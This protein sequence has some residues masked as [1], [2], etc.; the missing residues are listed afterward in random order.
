MKRL[1]ISLYCVFLIF[2]SNAIAVAATRLL[3]EP[4]IQADKIVFVKAGDLWTVSDKGGEAKRLTVHQ[5]IEA[6]PKFSPDGKW[7][8]FSGEYDGN[9]DVFIIPSNGGEP[10]RLTYHP[11]PDTVLGWIPDGTRILFKSSRSSYSGFNRLFT[12]STEGGFPEELPIPMVEYA[13]YSP[14]GSRLAYNP[15]RHFQKWRRYRGGSTPAV[16][17]LN[18]SDFSYEEIP[19]EN[20]SDISP[21]WMGNTV[22]FLSDRDRTLDIYAYDVSGKVLEHLVKNGDFDIENLS[23]DGKRLVYESNGDLYV[24]DPAVGNPQKLRITVPGDQLFVRKHHKNVSKEIMNYDLSP[25]GARAVFEAH[26]EVLTVPAKKGNIR[27]LTRSPGVMDRDPAWSPNGKYIS[28]FSDK[29]GEYALYIIDQKGME[30]AKKIEFKKPSF[31]Y[32]PTWSPDSKK[33]VFTDKHMNIWYVDIEKKNPVKVDTDLFSHPFRTLDPVWS[34]DSNWIAYVR[35]LDNY[36]RTVFVYSLDENKSYQ[37]TDGMSDALYPVFDPEGKYLY[38]TA[39][40][41]AGQS[42]GWLDLTAFDRNINMHIYLVVL[43]KDLPSPLA[44]ESDEEKPEEEQKKDPPKK[45]EKESEKKDPEK[46]KD[47][48]RIDLENIDQRII[49]LPVPP[50]VYSHLRAIKGKF[51]FLESSTTAFFGPPQGTIMLFDFESRKSTTYLTNVTTFNVSADGKKL[52][53][54]SGDNWGIIDTSNKPKPGDGK[55]NL[56]TMDIQINPRAEWK[57][58]LIE[59]WRINRD[60]FYDPGMH[61]VDWEAIR[62]QYTAFL[63]YVAHRSDL[64]FLITEMISEL[65]VGHAYAG[66]GN[67]PDVERVLGGL[68]GADY[69]IENGRYRIKKIYSGLNW[70]PNLRAPLTEPGVDISEGDFI[71]KVNGKP[72]HAPTNIFSL[73][74]KTTEK[75]VT[76][77]VNSSP[78]EKGSRTATVVPIWNEYSLRNRAWVEGN[79]RRVEELSGGRIGYVYLPDTGGGGYTYFNRYFFSQLDKDGLVIDERFNGGGFVADYIIDYLDRPLLSYWATRD[80]KPFATPFASV[81]GP[82]AMIIN[83]YAGSGGDALPWMFR[84]RKIGPLVGKRTWGGLVGIYD[85][86]RLM[87]GGS[88][89]SP[90]VAIFSKDSEWIVENEGVAP[91]YPVELIPAEVI[92]GKD[93]QL[94]KAVELVMESLKKSLIPKPKRPKPAIKK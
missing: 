82:K 58:M 63:P 69:E 9:R 34:P 19:H 24:Y 39:S 84:E 53:Y 83:E 2:V 66:G 73:F 74:E 70:N 79:R 41:N 38:F 13:D 48:F 23:G 54:L 49:A 8:A 7:I 65:C 1:N 10:K 85:Y 26:G 90:R 78:E 46:K 44:P 91:D 55:L 32:S 43:R 67:Y 35:K 45:E 81:L 42:T 3:H 86:P 77:T 56:T 64:N 61:G 4:D 11:Y 51:F 28:Y 29:G 5:G 18:L 15:I 6:S 92:K 22:Y 88:V 60:F 36:F 27:N 31:Y 33:L 59:A 52:L 25:T 75:Q 87:D 21:V 68:L 40:T 20:A 50:K 80:G 57:Q 89:T 72:L 93:P 14:E 37:I 16:W 47:E 12:I 30:P 94:E 71:I 76:L 17:L 62:N